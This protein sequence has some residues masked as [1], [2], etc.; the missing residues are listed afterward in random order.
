[1]ASEFLKRFD[2]LVFGSGLAGQAVAL[3]LADTHRVALV[4]KR[5]IDD[6]AT[7]RAQGGIAA[8][9]NDADSIAAHIQDTLTAGAGL[10]DPLATRFVVERGRE[11]I[12]WLIAQGVPFTRGES[13]YHLTREGGHSHRR[14]RPA[15]LDQQGARPSQHHGARAAHRH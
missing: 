13:G 11:A 10:C 6:S 14:G 15:D 3:R 7:A 1:M 4:T 8:V 5:A 2:V 12:E 9:L